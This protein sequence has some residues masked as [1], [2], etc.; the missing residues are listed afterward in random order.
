MAYLPGAG[1][2]TVN[3]GQMTLPLGAKWFDPTSGKVTSAGDFS[4]AASQT[5]T[6][7]GNNSAGDNDWVLVLESN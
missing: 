3:L 6:T 7:P 2:I 4:S 5:F 1:T